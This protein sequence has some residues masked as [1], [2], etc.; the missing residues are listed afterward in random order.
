MPDY[1]QS[2]TTGPRRAES[3]R[4]RL[5]TREGV[6]V[7]TISL[8]AALHR[9]AAVAAAQRGLVLTAVFR[10]SLAEWLAKHEREGRRRPS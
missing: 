6:M 3:S 9:R 4:G 7:T 1:R 5:T 10:Q 8:P 2:R